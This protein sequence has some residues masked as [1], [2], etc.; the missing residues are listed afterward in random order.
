MNI[1][2]SAVSV[3]ET[4]IPSIPHYFSVM[5]MQTCCLCSINISKIL[6]FCILFSRNFFNHDQHLE[7]GFKVGG[8]LRTSDRGRAALLSIHPKILQLVSAF[9]FPL[10]TDLKKYVAHFT[11]TH[12][13]RIRMLIK[14][15]SSP[16]AKISQWNMH[17]IHWFWLVLNTLPDYYQSKHGR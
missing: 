5:V 4:C 10:F 8:T 17:R 15:T 13:P 6:N 3:P 14:F 7:N 12:L 9:P 16:E 1:N 2:H 11:A